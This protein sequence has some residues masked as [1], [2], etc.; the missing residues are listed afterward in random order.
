MDYKSETTQTYNS[1]PS[2]FNEK[3]SEYAQELGKN[4]GT[5]LFVGT[6]N[7]SRDIVEEQANTVGAPY[8]TFRCQLFFLCFYAGRTQ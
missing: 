2:Y 6:K 4:G 8:L 1:F 7:Q 5:L 3:F